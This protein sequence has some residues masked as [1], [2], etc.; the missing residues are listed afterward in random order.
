MRLVIKCQVFK[1]QGRDL[2][3]RESQ[4]LKICTD[5]RNI[6][7]VIIQ[8]LLVHWQ[9][10]HLNLFITHK[11]KCLTIP[12]THMFNSPYTTEKK[13]NP[14][15]IWQC[16]KY[17]WHQTSPVCLLNAWRCVLL[18]QYSSDVALSFSTLLATL[19]SIPFSLFNFFFFRVYPDDPQCHPAL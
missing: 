13:L 6:F 9:L 2:W 10:W 11:L 4:C 1:E 12:S 14:F 15:S 5:T 3:S 16:C 17:R 18:K 7:Q 19:P 8:T